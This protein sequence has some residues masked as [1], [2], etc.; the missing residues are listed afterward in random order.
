MAD[1][2]HVVA[3]HGVTALFSDGDGTVTF[4]DPDDLVDGEPGT[5]VLELAVAHHGVAMQ[6]SNGVVL[7][8]AGDETERRSVLA[9]DPDG[10]ESARTDACPDV[11]GETVAAGEA[12]LFGCSGAVVVYENASF[13]TIGLPDEAA[14]VGGPV[15]TEHSSVVL[16]DYG[17]EDET[18]PTRVVMIDLA[19]DS[20]RLIELP[21]AYYYWSLART[22]DGLGLVLTTDG[23]LHLIDPDSG[24]VV[25]AIPVI[26]AWTAPEDW[27]DA[28]PSVKVL[29]GLAY[30]S[31]PAGNA[32]HA[33]DVATRSVIATADLGGTT[34]HSIALAGG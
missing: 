30:V 22:D 15:G 7:T 8:T 6:L 26:D 25:A 33:V 27:R 13:R 20:V 29:D 9:L 24:D 21:A 14:G 28:A 4:F 2:G 1:P 19:D 17:T 34:P 16:A 12:V 32:I 10:G 31:D 3:H 18:E 11:H 23:A 5:R